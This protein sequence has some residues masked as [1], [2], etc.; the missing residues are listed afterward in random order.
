MMFLQEI[1]M[2]LP[3]HH[4][5][6]D[7]LLSYVVLQLQEEKESKQILD[8]HLVSSPSETRNMII[9]I[10]KMSDG[11]NLEAEIHQYEITIDTS[12]NIV[13]KAHKLVARMP[14]DIVILVNSLGHG[15]R[16]PYSLVEQ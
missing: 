9:S 6:T 13:R 2:H 10:T 16:H 8:Y 15:N 12:F 14:M 7:A 4:V 5:V 11:N 3:Q 1:Y